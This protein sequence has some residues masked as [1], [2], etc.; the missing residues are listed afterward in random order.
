MEKDHYIWN[1]PSGYNPKLGQVVQGEDVYCPPIFYK[2]FEPFLKSK[3]EESEEK[4]NKKTTIKR[5]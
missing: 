3:K 2:E 4:E 5:R 1:G